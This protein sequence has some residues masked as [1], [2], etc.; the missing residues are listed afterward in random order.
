[1]RTTLVAIVFGLALAGAGTF[2]AAEQADRLT[3]GTGTLYIGAWP[4]R[5]FIIDEASEKVSGEITMSINSA[6]RAMTLSQNRKRF[7]TLNTNLED[8]EIVDLATR[9]IIDTFR[10]SQGAQKVRIRG[11]APDPLDRFLVLLVKASERKRDHYAIGPSTLVVYDLAKHEVTRTIKWPNDQERESANIQMSPDGKLLYLF[12]EEDT[13]IYS[14]DTFQQVDTWPETRPAGEEGLGRFE[15]RGMDD[16]NEEPGFYTGFFRMTDPVQHRQMM[17]IA[18]VDLGAK[19]I[20]FFTIGPSQNVGSFALA[21]GRKLAYGLSQ[22][23]G[24][25]EFW[26]FDMDSRRLM[27]RAEFKGRPRMSLRASSNGK[28]LYIFNAGNTID[29]YEAATYKYLRTLTLD[30]DTTTTLFVMPPA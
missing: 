25:Y 28:L 26:T 23:I 2:L 10:L 24:R 30:G 1:M 11:M 12:T 5:I 29:M 6:P 7:Y 20:D 4:N 13:I 9:K 15:M 3:G 16:T 27:N 8:V 19:S 14:T 17:G 18:R 22:Q 21:P